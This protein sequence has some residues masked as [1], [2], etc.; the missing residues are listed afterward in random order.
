MLNKPQNRKQK[1][2]TFCSHFIILFI[3]FFFPEIVM[4]IGDTHHTEIPSPVYIKSIMYLLVFYINYYFIIDRC[5]DGN[6]SKVRF[7]LYNIGLFVIMMALCYFMWE[8]NPHPHHGHGHHPLPPPDGHVH[9]MDSEI[10]TLQEAAHY[11]TRYIRDAVMIVLAMF[12]SLA[13]KMKSRWANIRHY[14]EQLAAMQREEELKSLKSQLN[15]H[16]L[17]N[18]LNS[19]YALIA[20][21]PDKAQWA[22]HELSSMLR[23]ILYENPSTVPVEH[24]VKFINS[25]IALMRLRFSSKAKMNVSVDIDEKMKN[26]EIAPLIF[27][28]IIENVFKHGITG[29]A[30]KPVEI[31]ITARDGIVKCRTFN[32][33]DTE[34][35][36]KKPSG[37]GLTNLRRRLELIYG[38]NAELKS[39]ALGDTFTVE[40]SINLYN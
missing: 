1:I 26:A 3:L 24:E 34:A 23:Y 18:T 40:L 38:G 31:S 28:T 36:G 30:S 2:V 14:K 15:P 13:L 37:I 6:N 8:Q 16:F 21:S 39:G 20:V 10:D 5:F 35:A 9:H 25:Y 29:D 11:I 12:L 7:T 22:V 27:I 4:N 19:I 17:F 32:H 33:F